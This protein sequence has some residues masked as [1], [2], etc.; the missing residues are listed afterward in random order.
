MSLKDVRV[1]KALTEDEVV[2]ALKELGIPISYKPVAIVGDGIEMDIYQLYGQ[3][4][5]NNKNEKIEP[6]DNKLSKETEELIEFRKLLMDDMSKVSRI[7]KE[8]LIPKIVV[9]KK[10]NSSHA[11]PEGKD[12]VICC[13]EVINHCYGPYD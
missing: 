3:M 8:Y 4:V 10:C 5:K 12:Y 7:P 2:N 1:S 13:G 9:C 6:L 11:I